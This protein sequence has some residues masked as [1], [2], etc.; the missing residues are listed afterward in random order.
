MPHAVKP[1]SLVPPTFPPELV[2]EFRAA[3][4]LA[5]DILGRTSPNPP[6]GALIFDERGE[7]IGR[8]ATQPPGQ[9]HAEVMALTDARQNNPDSH[10]H[11]AVVTL[12]PCNHTG[13]TGPC[14]QAL[15]DAGVHQVDF[16]FAD[17]GNREGGG[18]DTLRRAG[19][20]VRG[21]FLD[22]AHHHQWAS[23][24]PRWAV[25]AWLLSQHLGRPHITLKLAGTVDGRA[26]AADRS[27]QWI[28][29]S[30]SRTTAHL[31]R[32]RR[33]A[34]VVGTGTVVSDDPRLTARDA[35]GEALGEERQPLR[36]I[37]GHRQIPV[38]AKIFATPGTAIHLTTRDLQEVLEELGDRGI[39]TVLVEGGPA[40]AAAFLEAGLVDDIQAFMAPALLGN[41]IPVVDASRRNERSETGSRGR[42]GSSMS[43]IRRFLTREVRTHDGDIEWVLSAASRHHA[44][45]K[46]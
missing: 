29:N 2:A 45:R 24:C 41:G 22:V 11:R 9:A 21:P 43:E 25:E 30:A 26:A 42:L 16:L 18:A 17:P 10:P 15:I 23:D 12:E 6:V 46:I 3:D 33:D 20:R 40:L 44:H 14:A 7:I 32:A 38:S 19:I 39:V 13:R 31:D 34:I 37:V 1:E 8:G 35:H 4:Q 5:W 27:S 28:T 36:V